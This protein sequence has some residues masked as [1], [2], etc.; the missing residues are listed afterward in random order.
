[1]KPRE[2]NSPRRLPSPNGGRPNPVTGTVPERLGSRPDPGRCGEK[3]GAVPARSSRRARLARSP[4]GGDRRDHQRP[5]LRLRRHPRHAARRRHRGRR[6]ATPRRS[7]K[8]RAGCTTATSSSSPSPA[9]SPLPALQRLLGM[10]SEDSRDHPAARRAGEGLDRGR[11]RGDRGRADRL[12]PGPRGSRDHQPGP[13]QG[14]HL[15]VDRPRHPRPEE[16]DRR[17]GAGAAARDLRRRDGDRRA[18]ERRHRAAPHDGRLAD[19]DLAGGRGG[20]RLPSPRRHRRR[21]V[22]RAASWR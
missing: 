11:G 14:R 12:Q 2:Y 19:A 1:M 7:P 6:R 22:A 21:P 20:R 4:A 3:L 9:R 13:P 15:A 5:G 8:P 16:A 10:L 17:G 18:G